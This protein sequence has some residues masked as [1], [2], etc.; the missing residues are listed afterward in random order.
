MYVSFELVLIAVVAS[1]ATVCRAGDAT[2]S[3]F[4]YFDNCRRSLS[5]TRFD[6]RLTSEAVNPVNGSVFCWT[7]YVK[8]ATACLSPQRRCCS[9]SF[10]KVKL[11]TSRSCC[12]GSNMHVGGSSSIMA[13]SLAATLP[14]CRPALQQ[15]LQ[16]DASDSATDK[17]QCD[18]IRDASLAPFPSQGRMEPPCVCACGQPG[19][20]E[21]ATPSSRSQTQCLQTAPSLSLGFM[22][23]RSTTMSAARPLHTTWLTAS[24][25]PPRPRLRSPPPL[26][27]LLSS[28]P[29]MLPPPPSPE[30]P[31][32]LLPFSPPPAPRPPPFP[33]VAPGAYWNILSALQGRDS[34]AAQELHRPPQEHDACA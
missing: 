28:P 25:S 15:E 33:P 30:P 14:S 12:C 13:H 4:P 26:P 27:P 31:P 18:S 7:V 24:K 5:E 8:P 9:T 34:A 6:V 21:F 16:C 23:G 10:A 22:T 19:K 17:L 1:W 20:G 32:P 2:G 29:T 11:Y 3:G